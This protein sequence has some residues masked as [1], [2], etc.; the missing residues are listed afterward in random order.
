MAEQLWRKVTSEMS[1]EEKEKTMFAEFM[2]SDRIFVKNIREMDLAFNCGR[3]IAHRFIRQIEKQETVVG[4]HL[5]CEEIEE[6]YQKILEEI[7]NG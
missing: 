7:N 2:R 4:R 1:R 3:E 6:M 5:A